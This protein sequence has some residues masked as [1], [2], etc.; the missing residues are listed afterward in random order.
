[1]SLKPKRPRILFIKNIFRKDEAERGAQNLLELAPETE[2]N[3]IKV[4]SILK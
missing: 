2:D 3:Y 4:K 1:M